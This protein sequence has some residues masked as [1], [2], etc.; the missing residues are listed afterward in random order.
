MIGKKK[1]FDLW[2]PKGR[3]L[4]Q[5]RAEEKLATRASKR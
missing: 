5:S 2:Y 3:N 1:S 4:R